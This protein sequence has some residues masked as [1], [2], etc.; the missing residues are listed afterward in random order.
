MNPQSLVTSFVP[1]KNVA[2]TVGFTS[3]SPNWYSV[4]ASPWSSI[5][6]KTFV[7]GLTVTTYV[8]VLF[9]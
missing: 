4:L 9:S 5:F 3:S 7:G 1:S 2:I 8:N 6:C